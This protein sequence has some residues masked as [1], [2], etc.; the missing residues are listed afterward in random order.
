M[1][2]GHVIKSGGR[3]L[4]GFMVLLISFHLRVWIAKTPTELCGYFI[5]NS[6]DRWQDEGGSLQREIEILKLIGEGL[7]YKLIANQLSISKHTVNTHI[8]NM[9]AK[10]GVSNKM[11]L[12]S[13]IAVNS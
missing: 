12:V 8:K 13:R 6:N 9:F 10:V 4:S 2:S 5:R 7:P 1:A 3:L 11:E